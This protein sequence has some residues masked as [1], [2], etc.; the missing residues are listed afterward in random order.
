VALEIKVEMYFL[1]VIVY[2]WIVDV[3]GVYGIMR[4]AHSRNAV[5]ERGT[6]VHRLEVWYIL[7]LDPHGVHDAEACIAKAEEQRVLGI[8]IAHR[9]RE[10]CLVDVTVQEERVC[11]VGTMA[12]NVQRVPQRISL[13]PRTLHRIIR[14]HQIPY[15][16]VDTGARYQEEEEQEERV[17]HIVSSI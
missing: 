13:L 4:H 12:D 10:R 3:D 6:A 9:Q 15:R 8:G 16:A 14:P 17:F 11:P 7:L 5:K 2:K 1:R